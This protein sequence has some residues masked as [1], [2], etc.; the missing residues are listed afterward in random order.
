MGS[1]AMLAIRT[2]GCQEDRCGGS[3][4]NVEDDRSVQNLSQDLPTR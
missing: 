3:T 4:V 2:F 1:S